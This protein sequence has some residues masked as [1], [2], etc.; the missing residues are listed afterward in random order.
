MIKK[1]QYEAYGYDDDSEVIFE[2]VGYFPDG[3][4]SVYSRESYNRLMNFAMLVSS[5][6]KHYKGIIKHYFCGLYPEAD[7][8]AF[9]HVEYILPSIESSRIR[10][11]NFDDL[12]MERKTPLPAV[13][14][15][16]GAE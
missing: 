10:A 9:F 4:D 2:K 13:N 5:K 6:E 16:V 15:R 3:V 8:I 1:L 12:V 7:E 11:G 14:C